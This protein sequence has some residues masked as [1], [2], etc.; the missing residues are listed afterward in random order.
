M[1]VCAPLHPRRT[2]RWT[3]F[4]STSRHPY[5][6]RDSSP[7][8]TSF[9]E[10]AGV[11]NICPRSFHSMREHVLASAATKSFFG[12]GCDGWPGGWSSKRVQGS[13]I[14]S[15]MFRTFDDI[16]V[17][18]LLP[19][20][21]NIKRRCYHQPNFQSSPQPSV[22]FMVRRTSVK[23]V[24]GLCLRSEETTVRSLQEKRNVW[25]AIASNVVLTGL[26]TFGTISDHAFLVSCTDR[27][28]LSSRSS[29]IAPE[30]FS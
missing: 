21:V 4:L 2:C 20:S 10:M 3:N 25:S 23:N 22:T 13:N 19:L 18:S 9:N 24:L 5:Q 7:S 17:R 26:Y 30:R 12:Q 28:Y 6:P 14:L 11:E 27:I 1:F 15:P 8:S 16:E 29:A